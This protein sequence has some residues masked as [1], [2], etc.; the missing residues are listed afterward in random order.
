[1]RECRDLLADHVAHVLAALHVVVHTHRHAAP[2]LK[3]APPVLNLSEQHHHHHHH[4]FQVTTHTSKRSYRGERYTDKI[5]S[6]DGLHFEKMVEEGH[7]L[8][9]LAQTLDNDKSSNNNSNKQFQFGR[10]C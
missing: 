5:G 10:L 1:M 2:A 7:H 8:H 3:L 4:H 9:R 6:L